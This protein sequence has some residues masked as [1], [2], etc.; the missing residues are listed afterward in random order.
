LS[1][2]WINPASHGQVVI[3]YAAARRTGLSGVYENSRPKNPIWRPLPDVHG[4]PA[5]AYSDNTDRDCT[6]TV[7]LADDLSVDVGGILG[8]TKQSGD[9]A[10]TITEQIAGLVVDT[11]KKRAGS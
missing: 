3:T 11:L 7:G 8:K 6:V 4:F 9:D 2:S 10:C 5:V 1:C